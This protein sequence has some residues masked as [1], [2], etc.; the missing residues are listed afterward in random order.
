MVNCSFMYD[1]PPFSF[2]TTGEY[3]HLTHFHNANK[4]IDYFNKVN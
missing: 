1:F 4:P 3:K 2:Q